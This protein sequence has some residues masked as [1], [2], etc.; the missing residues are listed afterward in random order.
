[1][2]GSNFQVAQHSLYGSWLDERERATTE[3]YHGKL[4]NSIHTMTK[5]KILQLFVHVVNV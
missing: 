3:K 2:D 1:M 5:R 4:K